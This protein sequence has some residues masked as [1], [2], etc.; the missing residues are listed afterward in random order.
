MAPLTR[1][2]L[3]NASFLRMADEPQVLVDH[4]DD[5][6]ARHAG[7]AVAARVDGRV[8]G[9]A[10]QRHA[11]RFDHRGHGRGRAHGHAIPGERD[12]A[13]SASAKSCALITPAR[14]SSENFHT[15]VPEPMVAALEA[16]VEH[17][18]AGDDDGG[19]VAGR[20]AH[21]QRGRGLVAAGHQHG[22]VHRVAA[23]RLLDIH[24]RQVAEQH[25]GRA[26]VGFA[27]REHR[28]L[29]RQPAR[30]QDAGLDVLDQAAE[31]R[32]A[33]RE[34]GEGVADADHRAAVEGIVGQAVVLHPA[35][36]DEGVLARATEPVLRSS[37]LHSLLLQ[38]IPG[39]GSAGLSSISNI[40]GVIKRASLGNHRICAVRRGGACS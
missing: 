19:Q 21:D 7:E 17:R 26:Q 37:F 14:T 36:V 23:D 13:L 27:A 3:A 5:A 9:V 16:A 8:G 31:M 38:N 22:A 11:E 20:R 15:S 32:V 4:L 28:K 10:G 12:M 18:P 6:P 24:R 34:L 25:G 29:Q 33:G 30:L 1:M 39:N 2:A 35:S 40:I